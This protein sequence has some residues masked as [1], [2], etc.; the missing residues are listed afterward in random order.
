MNINSQPNLLLWGN[1]VF[2]NIDTSFKKE[3]KSKK[4][5]HATISGYVLDSCIPLTYEEVMEYTDN[6]ALACKDFRELLETYNKS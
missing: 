6:K 4:Y 2:I 3:H 5:L 1:N